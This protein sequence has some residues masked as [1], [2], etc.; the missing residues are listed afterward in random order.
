M[1]RDRVARP[2]SSI[3][4][5]FVLIGIEF[6]WCAYLASARVVP[7]GHDGLQYFYLKHYVFSA[8]VTG[9]EFPLWMPYVAHGIPSTW[10]AMLQ[11]GIF[12]PLALGFARLIGATDFFVIFYA[13]LFAEKTLL[14]VGTWLFAG[15]YLET[16][17]AVFA[18]TAAVSATAIWYAQPWWNLHAFVALPMMLFFV[19]R[20][21]N[22]FRWVWPVALSLLFYLQT[23]G[24]PVYYLPMTALFLALYVAV[25]LAHREP[26]AKRR[27]FTFSMAGAAAVLA[28][29]AALLTQLLWFRQSAADMAFGTTGRGSDGSVPLST[30][31][32]YGGYT[33]LRMWNQLFSSLTPHLDFT[34]FA[35]FLVA[36]LAIA[37]FSFGPLTR[38]QRSFAW[39]SVGVLLVC[40]AS[41]FATVLYYFWPL[42]PIFRHLS[43][44]APVV[45]IFVIL[46]AAATLDRFIAGGERPRIYLRTVLVPTLVMGAWLGVLVLFALDHERLRAFLAAMATDVVLGS[47]GVNEVS[48]RLG[49]GIAFLAISMAVLTALILA[50]KRGAATRWGSVAAVVLLV[51]VTA[52]GVLEMRARTVAL[53]RSEAPLFDLAAVPYVAQRIDVPE[54]APS[55]RREMLRRVWRREIG[56]P[57]WTENL[58]WHIDS[59]RSPRESIYWSAALDVL[60]QTVSTGGRR[61]PEQSLPPPGSVPVPIVAGLAAPK[62]RV[63]ARAVD[64]PA[65]PVAAQ[66]LTSPGYRGQVALISESAGESSGPSASHE[67]LPCDSK[68]LPPEAD[69]AGLAGTARAVSFSANRVEFEVTNDSPKPAVLTYADAWDAHWSAGVNG[70]VAPVLRS[71]LAYKAVVVPPGKSRVV[72]E[73]RDRMATY[74]FGLQALGSASLMVLLIVLGVRWRRVR[75]SRV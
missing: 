56:T 55:M 38:A 65:L 3:W 66:L 61:T 74:V 52:Y 1:H 7:A 67:V 21:L 11:S 19:H 45:K 10:W 27:P 68:A 23:F 6:V 31:L 72:F 18:A 48:R 15:E 70:T 50:A 49:Q 59:Y 44:L 30:F 42:A 26:A 2:S 33:D 24:Q 47:Y 58:L 64:C 40:T 16:R 20:T 54:A 4:P 35:G 57:Y 51:D 39:L 37:A 8:F 22:A 43:L 14:V 28:I 73:Y 41:P 5:L 17:P 71:D 29:G 69:G 62:A 9:G 63:M 32:N 46:L 75:Q 25:V 60:L 36:G 12:D 34:M 53:T 13:L